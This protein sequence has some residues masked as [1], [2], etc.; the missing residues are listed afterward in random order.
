MQLERQNGFGLCWIG[1]VDGCRD[2]AF[3]DFD[4]TGLTSSVFGS[5]LKWRKWLEL[6]ICLSS[7]SITGSALYKF[8]VPIGRAN[9]LIT[10]RRAYKSRTCK[11]LPDRWIKRIAPFF[12]IGTTRTTPLFDCWF[13]FCF[14]WRCWLKISKFKISVLEGIIIR[15]RKRLIKSG[16][17][18]FKNQQKLTF[19]LPFDERIFFNGSDLRIRWLSTGDGVSVK[20]TSSLISVF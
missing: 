5:E 4:G 18:W 16:N 12:R 1:A 17:I 8:S 2:D 6:R 11:K 10:I 3:N 19:E 20:N 15:A 7:H 9:T 13:S 14:I